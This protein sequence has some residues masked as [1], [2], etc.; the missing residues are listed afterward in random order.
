MTVCSC[1]RARA[2]AHMC[3]Y[4]CIPVCVCVC[5]CVRACV[6]ACVLY[7]VKNIKAEIMPIFHY[8]YSLFFVFVCLL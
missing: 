5:V 8:N 3:V 4:T 1:V 2:R 6:R 7:L